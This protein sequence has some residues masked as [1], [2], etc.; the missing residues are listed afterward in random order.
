MAKKNRIFSSNT[1]YVSSLFS[2]MGREER[3]LRKAVDRMYKDQKILNPAPKLR[4]STPSDYKKAIADMKELLKE[5]MEEDYAQLRRAR[6]EH[7]ETKTGEVARQR[8]Q[9]AIDST[10]GKARN[11]ILK[12]LE[13][14]HELD[15][16]SDYD[17]SE[18]L[19]SSLFGKADFLEQEMALN[20]IQQELDTMERGG[21]TP[22]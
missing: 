19:Y 18:E 11:K 4:G 1:P 22:F 7:S 13:R 6:R 20:T 17:E 3:A 2:K 21:D 8:I 9:L 12:D 14:A 16:E 5:G 10:Y 15:K